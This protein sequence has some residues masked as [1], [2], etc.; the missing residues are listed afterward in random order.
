MLPMSR[1]VCLC[2][3]FTVAFALGEARADD[4]GTVKDKLYQAKKEY[5]GEAR[6]FR[7]AVSDWLEKREEAARKAGNKKLLDQV[8]S[9][10]EKYSSSGEIPSDCPKALLTQISTART[11]LDKAYTAAVRDL[12]KLKEDSA[13]EAIEKE[14][15][16][17]VLDAALQFGAR[18]YL[19]ALKHS[20]VRVDQNWFSTN[21]T[22]S[23]G[24][25]VKVDGRPV[26]HSIFL[27]P[28]AKGE[29]QVKY[30]LDAKWVA[31]RTTVGVPKIEEN[32]EN[33]ASALTFEVL[34]DGKSVWKSEPVSKVGEFQ[35]CTLRVEKVKV[36]TLLVHCP[37]QAFWCRAFWFEPVLAP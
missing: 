4:L 22:G 20:D 25:K 24:E 32:T 15:E 9:E 17:F 26:P 29:A 8:K 35:T 5:D 21:G 2:A 13:A 6:K 18:T 16:K 27:H 10:K 37:D 12:V 3:T 1:L 7:K 34:A 31:F 14:R 28:P 30:A 19:V 23:N 11:K 36:L 33:P